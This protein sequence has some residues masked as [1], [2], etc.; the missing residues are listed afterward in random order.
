[1]TFDFIILLLVGA[2]IYLAAK[3]HLHHATLSAELKN[4][5]EKLKALETSVADKA[6]AELEALKAKVGG[7]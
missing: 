7:P 5:G 2:A 3:S 1:M 4:Q 6:K